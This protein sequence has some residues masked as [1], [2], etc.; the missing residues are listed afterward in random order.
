MLDMTEISKQQRRPACGQCGGTGFVYLWSVAR[1]GPRTWFCDR[2]KR[3][4][5][6]AD[7]ILTT[8]VGD[9]VG[10]QGPPPVLVPDVE[11]QPEMSGGSAVAPGPSPRRVRLVAPTVKAARVV[12]L[13]V[14]APD[15]ANMV[16]EEP[17]GSDGRL[18]AP[19]PTISG[20]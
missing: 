19:D 9:G 20:R 8:P 11:P 2:C 10:V 6:D 5:S 14:T 18:D 3:T 13:D 1:A 15:A 12:G 16:V 17:S 7:P 4:W